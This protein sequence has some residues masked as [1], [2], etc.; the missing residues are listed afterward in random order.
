MNPYGNTEADGGGWWDFTTEVILPGAFAKAS[1]A[2]GASG[3]PNSLSLTWGVS[4]DATSYEYCIDTS[5]NSTCDAVWVGVGNTN[6]AAL[7]GLADATTYYWQVR[8][9]N[10]LGDTEANNGAWWNFTT[11][12]PLPEPFGKIGPADGAF[13]QSLDVTLSWE[14]S[15]FATSYEYC[16]D[17]SADDSCDTSWVSA[18]GNTSVQPAGL[19]EMTYYYWQVRAVN[20]SGSVDADG[21]G[22]WMFI[23]TPLLFEDGVEAGDTSRWTVTVP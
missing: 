12:I 20:T 15:S 16:I 1:P 6:S 5:N 17:T 8:A 7:V 10:S 13:G 18:G 14:T 11:L 21:G 23:T 4:S 19:A 2:N 9:I 3:Q 22:A